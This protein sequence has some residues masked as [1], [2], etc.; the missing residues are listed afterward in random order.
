MTHYICEHHFCPT[1]ELFCLCKSIL[2][3]DT[4]QEREMTQRQTEGKKGGLKSESE[5]K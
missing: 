1:E 4:E 3:E 5:T 2:R